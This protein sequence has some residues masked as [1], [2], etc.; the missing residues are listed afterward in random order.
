MT[1]EE[2]AAADAAAEAALEA[3]IG[4]IVTRHLNGAITAHTKR[5]M[6]AF[7][8]TLDE[9]LAKLAPQGGEKTDEKPA[10]D[11]AAPSKAD[12]EVLKLREQ[13][14]RLTRTTEE[15]TKARAET[16]QKARLTATR[17][18][19]R[20]ALDAKGIKGARATA[21]LA[22]MEQQ[23][24]LRFTEDGTP[25]L[26]V[27]RAR[28]KGAKAEDLAFDDLAAGIEDW[29]KSEIAAEFLPPP[30][31][32][33]GARRPGIPGLA[34]AAAGARPANR[35]QTDAEVAE[36]FARGGVDLGALVDS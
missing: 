14:E 3:R 29:S 26:V 4:A 25:E 7:S 27:K 34:P 36:S 20:E 21:V 35:P 9:R 28:M 19:L 22:L 31:P 15:A 2:K 11:G 18:T 16:E 30:A 23:G 17:A 24:A 10:G 33:P 5:T 13:V 6:D 12:P 8:K 1:D 32:L